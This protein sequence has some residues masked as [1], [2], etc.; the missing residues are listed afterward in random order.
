MRVRGAHA[1]VYRSRQSRWR[2]P[3]D[4][5]EE[6]EEEE[7]SKNREL[8]RRDRWYV[9]KGGR[10]VAGPFGPTPLGDRPIS[11]GQRGWFYGGSMHEAVARL[12]K[13]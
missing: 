1:P 5:K 6:E 7:V 12:R 10:Y 3:A 11:W 8:D 13:R 4:P 9:R 2:S